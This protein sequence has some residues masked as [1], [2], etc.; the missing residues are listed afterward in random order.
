[1]FILLLEL[2]NYLCLF[3]EFL[4]SVKTSMCSLDPLSSPFFWFS[5]YAGRHIAQ[6]CVFGDGTKYEVP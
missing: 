5:R 1:M 2:F 3:L 4:L 6:K